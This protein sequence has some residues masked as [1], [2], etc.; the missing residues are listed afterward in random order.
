GLFVEDVARSFDERVAFFDEQPV[1]LTLFDLYKRPLAVELVALE[2]EEEFPFFESLPPILERD[3]LA[4][5]PDDDA[6]GTVVPRRNHTLEVAVLQRMVFDFDRQPLVVH[7]VRR[8]FGN[9]PR[10]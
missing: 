2:L 7:V 5:V 3:P 6:A 8:S 9:R 1:F 10:S 4:A